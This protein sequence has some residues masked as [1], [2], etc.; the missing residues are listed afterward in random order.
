MTVAENIALAQGYQ[1]SRRTSSTGAAVR[2]VAR[3]SLPRSP[4]TSIPD[5]ASG[6]LTRTEKS[7]VAIARALGV[8]AR[9][10][11]L[12]EPTASLPQDEVASPLQ[13]AARAKDAAASA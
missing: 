13:G 12:D 10:L 4:M 9:V 8:N 11:V 2:G 6:D 5:R 1:R 3:R 7:L